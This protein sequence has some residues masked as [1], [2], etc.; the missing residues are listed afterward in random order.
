M[1]RERIYAA[2]DVLAIASRTEGQSM[3]LMEA[4]AR[5]VPAIATRVGGNPQLVRDGETG[6]LVPVGDAVAIRA[7]L[8]R[9][10]ADPELVGRLG[11]ACHALIAARHS[12]DEVARK[13][14]ALYDRS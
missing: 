13:Y 8:A 12:I 1:D 6:V 7:A 2:I 11:R 14:D 9:M 3:A 4:M 10:L 5:G